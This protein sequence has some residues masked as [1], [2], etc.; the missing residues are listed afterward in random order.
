MNIEKIVYDLVKKNR[1]LK[2]TLKII[3]QSLLL[4]FSYFGRKLNSNCEVIFKSKGFFGFHDRPSLNE[5]GEMLSHVFIDNHLSSAD[6]YITNIHNNSQRKVA[7]TTCCSRQQGSLLTWLEKNK[8]IF[9]DM[10]D[11]KPLTRIIDSVSG[12]EKVLN[13]HFFSASPNGKLLSGLNFHRFGIGLAGYGY[14]VNYSSDV[15]LDGNNKFSNSSVS[16]FFIYDLESNSIL[17]RVTMKEARELSSFLIDD[18]YFYFSHSSFSPDSKKVYFLLRS[19]NQ[20]YNS[21]QLFVL[22][23]INGDLTPLMT[24]GMVSHLS[25]LSEVDIVAYCNT[26]TSPD[27]YYIINIKTGSFTSLGFP[28]V[29]GHPN[30]L[31]S[32]YFVTDTYPNRLRRQFLYKIDRY[33]GES[34]HL[35]DCFS[36]LKFSG[37]NRVDLHPRMSRC[38]KYITIDTSFSGERMQLVLK[39]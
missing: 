37:V 25:W 34:E 14:N 4:P 35:F 2:D 15:L 1:I 3:Y 23:I 8:F 27:G 12:D 18:G 11:E 16:D 26:P 19:S 30:R 5:S 29:D 21:S 38:G 7:T 39:V 20:K 6:I 17:V 22:D 13:F 33:S 9:N 24:G 28:S 32:Q 31:S 36:S 10:A